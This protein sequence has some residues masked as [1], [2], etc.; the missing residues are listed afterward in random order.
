MEPIKE[1]IVNKNTDIKPI[2]FMRQ[3]GRYL[4]EFRAIRAKNTNFIELCLNKNLVPEITLQPLKRFNLDA[5]IVFSDI[6]MLPYGIGQE[7]EFKKDFGPLLGSIDDIDLNNL[8]YAD[9][10][11]RL[12][13]VYE[14]LQNLSNVI[15]GQNKSLIGFVGAPWTLLVYMLNKKSP[16]K[17]LSGEFKNFKNKDKLIQI[18]IE[19]L[20]LHIKNQIN[21]GST[22]IQIFDSW[23]GLANQNE[24]DHFIYEPTAELVKYVKS[25]NTPVICFPRDI[26]DY[27]QY[28]KK[29]NPDA[30]NIDY[31]IDIK[32]AVKDL[33]IPIQ[34]G[35]DPK[36]LLGDKDDLKREVKKILINFKNHPYIFNLGHGVLPQ[37]D[38]DTVSYL[39]NLVREY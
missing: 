36:I 31:N 2:W 7:V 28:I 1:V 18:V 33:D 34:G 38:P 19:Y 14:S 17:N 16:K 22:I 15:K 8:K 3:A 39:I 29:V 30:V 24:I 6:L 10:T 35:L 37:T 20:K 12:K 32:K 13:P 26:K 4:P 27:N 11:N 23:A 25:L 9:F 21:S 5:A